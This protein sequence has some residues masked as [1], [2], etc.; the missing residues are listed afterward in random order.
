MIAQLAKKHPADPRYQV[1][2]ASDQS[3][4]KPVSAATFAALR[5]LT[6]SSNPGISRQAREAWR[7]ALLSLD[8]VGES[9]APL[10]EYVAANPGDTAIGEKLA[11]VKEGKTLWRVRTAQGERLARGA[12]AGGPTE[13]LPAEVTLDGLLSAGADALGEAA[14]RAEADG[15]VR[16]TRGD[17]LP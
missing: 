17:R 2:L 8:P 9:L 12:L 6:A 16:G 1:A 14:T 4:R 7:R 13:L 11:S 3:G 15:P 5:D 10:R